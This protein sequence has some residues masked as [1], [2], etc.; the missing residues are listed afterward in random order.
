MRVAS[1]RAEHLSQVA[2]A[3]RRNVYVGWQTVVRGKGYATFLRRYS[4]GRGWTGRAKKVSPAYGSVAIWPGDTFGLS[5]R[6]GTALLSWGSAVKNR[7]VS[8]IWFATA[9]L[10]AR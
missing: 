7:P 5:T 10:P 9:K 1:S 3:G 8:D 4:L 2:P 6:G